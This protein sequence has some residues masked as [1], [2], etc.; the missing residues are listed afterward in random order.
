MTTPTW[1][2]QAQR[3]KPFDGQLLPL[4]KDGYRIEGSVKDHNFT[5]EQI[6]DFPNLKAIE[7][8]TSLELMCIDLDSFEAIN[9]IETK[10]G[11][12]LEDFKSWRIQ[13]VD[14]RLKFFF[15][16]TLAQQKLGEFVLRDPEHDLEVFSKSSTPVTIIG[17]RRESGIYRWYGTGPEKLSYCP[18]KIWNFIVEFKQEDDQKKAPK[19]RNSTNRNWRPARPCPICNRTKDD[20]CCIHKDGNLVQCHQGKTNLHK[21]F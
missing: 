5:V 19:T 1:I 2:R 10:S 14:D 6:L 18:E 11:M 8:R 16:R 12:I 9:Y 7:L 13:R 17:H 21:N 4:K 15:K 3:L 20:D